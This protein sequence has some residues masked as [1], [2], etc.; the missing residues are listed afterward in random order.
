MDDEEWGDRPDSLALILG[1]FS[2]SSADG[3]PFIIPRSWWGKHFAEVPDTIHYT[4]LEIRKQ[5]NKDNGAK[6]TYAKHT[7]NTIICPVLAALNIYCRGRRLG[8]PLTYPAA[9]YFSQH[10]Q[11]SHL[12][13]ARDTNIFL[14]H[15]ARVVYNFKKT[16]KQLDKWST[17]SIR[18]MACN[19]LHRARYS[20]TYIKNCLRWKSDA[21]L[22]YLLNTF[23]T[24]DEYSKSLLMDMAPPHNDVHW[25]IMRQR[26]R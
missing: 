24:A 22:M 1:D 16:D 10:H 17:H 26:C 13:T 19:L 25:K 9:I 3:T 18:V 23:Y 5:K 21:F 20:D 14:R 2:F 6:L 15:A 8:H 11:A 12:I 7:K 4:E